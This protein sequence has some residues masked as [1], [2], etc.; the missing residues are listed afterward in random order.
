METLNELIPFMVRQ[1]HHERNPPKTISPELVEG[2]IQSSYM[3]TI[4]SLQ[5]EA[6]P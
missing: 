5:I 6:L 1:A 2:L 4:N 3:L